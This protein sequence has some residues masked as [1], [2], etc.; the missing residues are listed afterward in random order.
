VLQ[1][2][3]DA[4]A[5]VEVIADGKIVGTGCGMFNELRVLFDT[6]RLEVRFT[7]NEPSATSGISNARIE[8][9]SASR[10]G[11]SFFVI[12]KPMKNMANKA[13]LV[14]VIVVLLLITG[15]AVYLLN[16]KDKAH[17]SN[18]TSTSATV[19]D[20]AQ[21]A[22]GTNSALLDSSSSP[23]DIKIN[24]SGGV[25]QVDTSGASLS[26]D[27]DGGDA[28]KIIDGNDATGWG[29][30]STVEGECHWWKMDLGS[31]VVGIARIRNV[32]SGEADSSQE[33]FFSEDDATYTS[34]YQ[35]GGAGTFTYDL[36]AA[37][38][39]RYVKV[40]AC[41]EYLFGSPDTVGENELT[42]YQGPFNATNKETIDGTASFWSWDGFTPTQTVP[43]NTSVTYRY[44][45]SANGTDWTSWVSS[46]GSVTSRT[47][48]DDNNPTLY[49]YLQVETTLANTDGASTPTVS[50]YNIDYHTEIKPAAPSAETATTQ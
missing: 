35:F 14:S 43:A 3:G 23:G 20:Q 30:E 11:P 42:L 12:I 37:Q 13:V 1:G 18:A 31:V 41:N 22:G 44:R 28:S 29:F 7:R 33:I 34:I 10:A 50:S 5:V 17:K 9:L 36:P 6:K 45:T 19:T 24:I 46:I 38:D 39:A 2:G 47:G 16:S 4:A 27:T 21:W 26:T 32:G 25:T 48:D 8:G 49:R 15:F 40:N